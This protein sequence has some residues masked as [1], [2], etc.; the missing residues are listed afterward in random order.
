MYMSM[1]TG[2]H[3]FSY[4]TS[5]DFYF[6]YFDVFWGDFV[7]TCW[8]HLQSMLCCFSVCMQA[9]I[10]LYIQKVGPHGASSTG[11]EVYL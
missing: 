6:Y 4:S 10:F 3:E 9:H 11:G 2:V 1:S 7:S 8:I 5:N